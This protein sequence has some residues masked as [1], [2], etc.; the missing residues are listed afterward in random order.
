M[1]FNHLDQPLEAVW[2]F[3][4][5]PG[6]RVSRPGDGTCLAGN[7][8]ER[9]WRNEPHKLP[10]RVGIE[11]S[12]N[13]SFTAGAY[14]FH[15]NALILRVGSMRL[16]YRGGIPATER[17]QRAHR[18][19]PGYHLGVNI[20]QRIEGSVC[21]RRFGTKVQVLV[22]RCQLP[23]HS[24]SAFRASKRIT[25]IPELNGFKGGLVRSSKRAEARE[26]LC[27]IDASESHLAP[28]R[29]AVPA[30]KGTGRS[31]RN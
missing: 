21:E 10:T 17:N 23:Q 31:D 24:D 3:V 5:C 18:H 2:V 20:A 6:G 7:R 1:P 14:S 16:Y 26:N 9:P 30:S 19:S 15:H 12:Y 22:H 25:I 29:V 4:A 13:E 28:P 11:W 27:G 8:L